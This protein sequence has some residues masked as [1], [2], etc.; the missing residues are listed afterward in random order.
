MTAN[1]VETK[2]LL[3]VDNGHKKVHYFLKQKTF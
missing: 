1:T 2:L 3:E